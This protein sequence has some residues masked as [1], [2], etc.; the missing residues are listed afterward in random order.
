LGKLAKKLNPPIQSL[1]IQLANSYFEKLL[2]KNIKVDLIDRSK[3]NEQSQA[4][5]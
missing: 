5:R 4:N 1:H 2:I 3:K